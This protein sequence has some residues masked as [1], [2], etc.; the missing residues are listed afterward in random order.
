MHSTQQENKL[1]GTKLKGIFQWCSN[2]SKEYLL[3]LSVRKTPLFS[4]RRDFSYLCL[5]MELIIKHGHLPKKMHYRL[6]QL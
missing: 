3:P 5:G 1:R 4:G 2:F 6:Q